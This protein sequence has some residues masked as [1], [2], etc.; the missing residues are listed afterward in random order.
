V[1]FLRR[2]SIG[3]IPFAL[4]FAL[5][6]TCYLRPLHWL[7]TGDT[8]D[9]LIQKEVIDQ[10]L[11]P[12]TPCRNLD[13]IKSHITVYGDRSLP[14]ELISLEPILHRYGTDER[15]G[16]YATATQTTPVL[17]IKLLLSKTAYEHRIIKKKPEMHVNT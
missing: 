12:A 17:E 2:R 4:Q 11:G 9:C 3:L 8:Q 5:E 10:R 7:G 14:G 6:W 16:S 1:G 15:Q 13:F